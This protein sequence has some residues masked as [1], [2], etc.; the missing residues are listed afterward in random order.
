MD[1]WHAWIR[2]WV[3]YWIVQTKSFKD[4]TK[5]C[6]INHR[7]NINKFTW[8]FWQQHPKNTQGLDIN[9]VKT[10]N[11]INCKSFFHNLKTL[12]EE[13]MYSPSNIWNANETSV[14]A[15]R[16]NNVKVLSRH[17]SHDVYGVIPKAME[18]MIVFVY[19]NV[20]GQSIPDSHIFKRWKKKRNY[21]KNVN[22]HHNGHAW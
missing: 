1:T 10:L 18:L 13:Y 9:R 3:Q 12:C 6:N 16:I 2:L 11:Q 8:W 21:M 20:V 15:R 4:Y 5:E 22:L 7:W 17:G 19:M 14:Q